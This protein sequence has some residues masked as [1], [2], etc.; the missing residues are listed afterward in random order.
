VGLTVARV[1]TFFWMSRP[2]LPRILFVNIYGDVMLAEAVFINPCFNVLR[3][4]KYPLTHFDEWGAVPSSAPSLQRPD[5]P[6]K[7]LA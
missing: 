1:G 6:L 2:P 7:L 3:V 5:G 4:V